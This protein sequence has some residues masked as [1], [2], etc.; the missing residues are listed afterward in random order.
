[1]I[2]GGNRAMIHEIR[3]FFLILILSQFAEKLLRGR[4]ILLKIVYRCV[5]KKNRSETI[6]ES[7]MTVIIRS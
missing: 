7:V 1:M 3:G 5:A 4:F 6:R 2:E